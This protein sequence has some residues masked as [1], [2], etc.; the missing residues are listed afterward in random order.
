MQKIAL[1]VLILAI[2]RT[3][4]SASH[5]VLIVGDARIHL[6]NFEDGCSGIDAQQYQEELFPSSQRMADHNAH[7][8]C[9]KILNRDHGVRAERISDWDQRITVREIPNYM[10][11]CIVYAQSEA[12]YRCHDEN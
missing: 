12:K 9:R 2:T 10:P 1:I 5:E 6:G 11:K 3:S 7:K 4:H 8:E